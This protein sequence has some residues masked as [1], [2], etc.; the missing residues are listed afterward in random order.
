MSRLDFIAAELALL[1]STGRLRSLRTVSGQ[2]DARVVLDGREVLNLSSNNYLGLANH[3][4]L[5]DA[6]RAALTRAGAGA[7]ASRLIVGNESAHDELERALARFH[8]APAARLF[9]SG[10]HANTGVIP[11]LVGTDDVVFSD[12]LNHASIIDGCRL[13]R[14]RVVVFPHGDTSALERLMHEHRGGRRLVVSDS[15]FSMDGD[16][17]DV[18]GLARV[19]HGNGALLMLDEAHAVGA[20]GPG[21]RGVAASAG[22][23]PDVL[24]GTLGKA[25]G[26]FGAYA[27]GSAALIQLLLNRARS[28]VFTTALPPSVAAMGRAAV[29]LVGGDEGSRRRDQLSERVCQMREGLDGL[30]LL[31]AG[32]GGSAIF[33]LLVGDEAS[34]MAASAAL[35][36]RGIFVQG[37][38]PPTVPAGTSRLRIALMATHSAGQVR[39]VLEALGELART[40]F[41]PQR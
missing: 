29:E 40:G 23:L 37:I 2:Q 14:A 34:A 35:L 31:A 39:E 6:A 30:G 4:T 41:I 28:F 11:T 12:A 10:Y 8:R 15:V 16:A 20:M 7:G 1:E 24:V 36:A 9:N 32:S 18:A 26:S 27:V 21:G 38:R 19:T 3:H 17:A 5:L 25:F 33:P 22:V 13:S